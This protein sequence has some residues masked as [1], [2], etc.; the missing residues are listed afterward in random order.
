MTCLTC[1]K[2][3]SHDFEAD[4]LKDGGAFGGL[5]QI[6]KCRNCGEKIELDSI[7]SGIIIDGETFHKYL[8]QKEVQNL[9]KD[10]L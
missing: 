6:F 5:I 2:C 9:D 10:V 4:E 8:L 7:C 1:A 3:H